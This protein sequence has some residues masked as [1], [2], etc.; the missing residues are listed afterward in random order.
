MAVRLAD[1]DDEGAAHRFDDIVG[2]GVQ[3]VDF[4]TREKDG[5]RS[6][7]IVGAP[8]TGAATIGLRFPTPQRRASITPNRA[9]TKKEQPMTSADFETALTHRIWT[10]PDFSRLAQTSPAQALAQLGVQ[11]P[12]GAEIAIVVQRPDTL[13]FAI[14]PVR[15]ASADTAFQQTQMD[16]WGSGDSFVW[17]NSADQAA[18]MLAIRSAMRAEGAK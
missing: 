7:T 3:L 11:I 8:N 17:I 2:G 1:A 9:L 4:M 6:A 15:R 10:D 16:I 14:P 5:R 18:D 12:E 13:H